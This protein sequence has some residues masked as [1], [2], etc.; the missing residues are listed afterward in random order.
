MG[1]T[2]FAELASLKEKKVSKDIKTLFSVISPNTKAYVVFRDELV[3]YL[4][5]NSH[6]FLENQLESE[7]TKEIKQ[8]DYM[9]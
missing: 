5:R 6:M 7:Q 1:L 8:V 9:E 4:E 3:K 2:K